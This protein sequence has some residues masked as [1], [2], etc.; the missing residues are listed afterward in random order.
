MNIENRRF[1]KE[2]LPISYSFCTMSE[3]KFIIVPRYLSVYSEVDSSSFRDMAESMQLSS[4][5]IRPNLAVL[6]ISSDGDTTDRMFSFS[7]YSFRAFSD[8]WVLAAVVRPLSKSVMYWS[9]FCRIFVNMSWPM[10]SEFNVDAPSGVIS[11]RRTL[12]G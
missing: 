5:K 7:V 1:K 4:P 6:E 11:R 12:I 2:N 8:T 9:L 3:L 10:F